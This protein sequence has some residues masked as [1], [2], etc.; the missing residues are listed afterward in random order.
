MQHYGAPTRLLDWTEG[1][2]IALYFAVKQNSGCHDA[3]VWLLDPWELK[4]KVV[5][6]DWV[7]AP[8]EPGTSAWD[9]R[10]Y[11]RWLPGRF[12]R[13][14]RWPRR[15]AAIYPG[16]IVRRIG[17]QRSCFTIHGWERRGL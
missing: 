14:K 12:A 15:P 5:K 13:G 11:D 10:L 3:A 7:V 6:Q 16:H 9:R 8:G 1:A 2:L 4:K 17:A